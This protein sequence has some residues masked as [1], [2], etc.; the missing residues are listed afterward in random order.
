MDRT[1]EMTD[2]VVAIGTMPK[3]LY[4]A[5]MQAVSFAGAAFVLPTQNRFESTI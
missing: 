1:P 3:T 5:N 2:Q 4:S